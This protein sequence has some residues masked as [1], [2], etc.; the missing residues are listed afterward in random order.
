VKKLS[1]DDENNGES[2]WSAV[3]TADL[4][5]VPAS[6]LSILQQADS[7]VVSDNDAAAFEAWAQRIDGWESAAPRDAFGKSYAPHPITIE[8]CDDT[9]PFDSVKVWTTQGAFG[10]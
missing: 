4:S 7:V 2:F 6:C 9:E 10:G 1:V 8:D 5:E 3:S